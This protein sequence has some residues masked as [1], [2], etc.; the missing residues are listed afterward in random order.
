MMYHIIKLSIG[1]VYRS[2]A[3]L[4]VQLWRS[5]SFGWVGVGAFR[6]RPPKRVDLAGRTRQTHEGIS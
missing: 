5:S 4:L 3:L 2:T 1:L 6:R